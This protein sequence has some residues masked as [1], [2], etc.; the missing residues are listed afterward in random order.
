MLEMGDYA[1]QEHT[2]IASLASKEFKNV[3][4]VG[5][6][7]YGL[8]DSSKWFANQAECANYLKENPI[9]GCTILLKGSRGVKLEGLLDYL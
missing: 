6:N 5:A 7:F 4:L 8:S 1:E 3:F 9:E 2:R